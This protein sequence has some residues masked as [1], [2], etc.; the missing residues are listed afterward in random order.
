MSKTKVF[1][2]LYYDSDE[3]FENEEE[4][5]A[6]EFDGDYDTVDEESEDKCEL[7]QRLLG[8][9]ANICAIGKHAFKIDF[10]DRE[11][12]EFE[13]KNCK[14]DFD[15]DKEGFPVMCDG[16]EEFIAPWLKKLSQKDKF[17][18]GCTFET[19]HNHKIEL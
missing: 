8:E 15:Y 12:K 10:F 1:N 17:F 4:L 18:K 11:H 9:V 14:C 7:L 2:V 16:G 6:V 3:E 5:D 19:N 13:A